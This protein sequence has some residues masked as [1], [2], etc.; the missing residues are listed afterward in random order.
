[1]NYELS[2]TNRCNWHCDYCLVDTHERDF[3]RFGTVLDKIDLMKNNSSVT[4]SGGEPGMLANVEVQ[5]LFE[6]LNKKNI[7]IDLLTNGLFLDWHSDYL[8]SIGEV[9]Y[10]CV[11]DLA[12]RT[13][14]THL[15]YK[16]KDDFYYILVVST[17]DLLNDDIL[18]YFSKYPDIKFV[19]SANVKP[20]ERVDISKF[21]IFIE[22]YKH[23][24]H[25]RTKEE[26]IRNISKA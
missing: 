23:H 26:L 10:H 9:F 22:R 16:N 17:E 25:P 3:L 18:Y 1:M 21:L 8:T 13:D 24:I 11:E 20:G 7:T 6:K 14:I 4:L 12:K 15:E 5:N 19:L 2:V